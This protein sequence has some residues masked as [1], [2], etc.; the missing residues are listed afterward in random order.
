MK[1]TNCGAENPE[2]LM[3]IERSIDLGCHPATRTDLVRAIR[4][5]VRRAAGT[6]L[7]LTYCLDGDIA[8]IRIP[9]ILRAGLSHDA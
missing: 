5:L 4:V 2:W 1:C 7:D 8:R 6:E 3:T 9:A